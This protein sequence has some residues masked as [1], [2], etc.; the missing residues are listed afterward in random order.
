MSNKYLE[1]IAALSGL[2]TANLT[3]RS[4]QLA[5]AIT[6]HVHS[7]PITPG[8][9]PKIQK[10]LRAGG[11]EARVSKELSDREMSAFTNQWGK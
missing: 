9:M 6:K 7:A 1:K 8:S 2:S 5:S 10:A 11:R 3:R 4:E